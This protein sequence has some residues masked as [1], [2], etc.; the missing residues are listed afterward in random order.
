M[1]QKVITWTLSD[2]QLQLQLQ[3][4]TTW[5]SFLQLGHG[6][7]EMLTPLSHGTKVY[8]P[9]LIYSGPSAI[10]PYLISCNLYDLGRLI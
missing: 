2:L 1:A 7:R 3:L 10:I 4:C 6:P 5:Y 8:H 9:S